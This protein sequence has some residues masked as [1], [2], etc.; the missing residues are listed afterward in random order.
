LKYLFTYKWGTQGSGDG[1]FNGPQ[2]IAVDA[3]GNVYVADQQ[4][5]R[6][7]KFQL[8]NPCPRGTSKVVSGVCFVT[9]LGSFGS[10]TGQFNAFAGLGVDSSGNAYVA[11]QQNHRIQMF[12]PDGTFLR[13]LGSF[14][15]ENGELRF[16][17]DV[18][19]HSSGIVFRDELVYVSDT[20]NDLIQVFFWE[21]DVHPVVKDLGNATH[22][23]GTYDLMNNT[24]DH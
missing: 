21:P 2:G 8:S 24:S 6:I 7:Q 11:D 3:S 14:G 13:L 1:Q 12:K 15:F 19:V 23:N 16:P 22:T 20:H 4:N 17:L 5:H 9:K 10:G 18:A